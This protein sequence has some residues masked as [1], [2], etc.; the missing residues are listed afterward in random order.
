MLFK[1]SAPNRPVTK[2]SGGGFWEIVAPV[3]GFIIAWILMQQRLSE[4]VKR[5]ASLEESLTAKLKEADELAEGLKAS[6]AS[7]DGQI[8]ELQALVEAINLRIRSLREPLPSG[9]P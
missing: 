6:I 7:K 8:S 4:S 9:P 3:L 1:G 2:K 5:S